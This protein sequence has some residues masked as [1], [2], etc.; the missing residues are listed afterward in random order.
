MGNF[1]VLLSAR[2][3]FRVISFSMTSSADDIAG[4]LQDIAKG[5]RTAFASLYAATSSKLLGVVLR[6]LKRRDI[7]EEVL[8]EVYVKIWEKAA[9]FDAGRASPITWM[10]TIARNRALDVVRQRTPVSLEDHPEH[11]DAAADEELAID[12]ILRDESGQ[13]LR[14]CLSKLDP[15]RARIIILA[16]C[17]GLSREELGQRY[18]QPANTIKTWLRRSLL[19]LRGCLEQ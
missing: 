11:L 10:S 14:D 12:K 6:I 2:F 5:D 17:E 19:Q 9:D 8:Q 4:F 1:A 13:A 3:P 15:D 7:A 18:N 16:Y